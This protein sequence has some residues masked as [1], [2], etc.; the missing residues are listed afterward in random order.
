VQ[1]KEWFVY[2][3]ALKLVLSGHETELD[4]QRAAERAERIARM[5]RRPVIA[6]LPR[7]DARIQEYAS[8]RPW[9]AEAHGFSTKTGG[10]DGG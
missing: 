3:M 2:D 4:A 5:H 6:V 10:E 8:T 1:R 7:G 9:W